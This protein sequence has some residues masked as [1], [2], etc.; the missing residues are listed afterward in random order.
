MFGL[1]KPRGKQAVEKAMV[2]ARLG[3]TNEALSMALH[4]AKSAPEGWGVVSGLLITVK[5]F[6][7]AFEAAEL[8]LEA[9][10]SEEQRALAWC[11]KARALI[12][13]GQVAKARECYD[14][15]MVDPQQAMILAACLAYAGASDNHNRDSFIRID[16]LG[17]SCW[18]PAAPRPER[19]SGAQ[20]FS[21]ITHE[22][23]YT[24]SCYEIPSDALQLMTQAPVEENLKNSMHRF[25]DSGFQ[26]FSTE[27][28]PD[29][30][31]PRA[32]FGCFQERGGVVQLGRFWCD[33]RR[34]RLL[35][36]QVRFQDLTRGAR[37]EL[38]KF[39]AVQS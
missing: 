28:H 36:A 22:F 16:S 4:G 21:V 14:Q 7:E 6:P 11:N 13:M 3:K 2:L 17:L 9:P 20:T 10:L 25:V 33:L 38:G 23:S 5:R 30:A 29:E 8:A 19:A 35:A 15:T 27:F 34:R 24:L 39:L 37:V 18:F 1:F 12:H 32:D 31:T 26:L